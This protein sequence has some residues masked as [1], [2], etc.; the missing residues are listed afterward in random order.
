MA[1]IISIVFFIVALL[2]G[3]WCICDAIYEFKKQ[4]YFL[5]GLNVMVAIGCVFEL[6]RHAL[7]W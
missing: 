6:A 5:F 1:L 3:A 7:V 4:R 2:V